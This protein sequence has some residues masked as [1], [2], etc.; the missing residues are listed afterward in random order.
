VTN[1]IKCIISV[2][3]VAISFQGFSQSCIYSFKKWQKA[4]GLLHRQVD[5]IFQDHYGFMWFGFENGIQR[6]DGHQFKSW[7][8]IDGSNKLYSI[9]RFGEDD[10][11]WLWLWNSMLDE[12]LFLNTE[13]EE[14]QTEKG[15]LKRNPYIKS[16]SKGG[17]WIYQ[18]DRIPKD[19]A[20]N[21]VFVIGS[22]NRI[23]RF[24]SKNGFQATTIKTN[25]KG[26]YVLEYL[27][28]HGIL[29]VY[30]V[31]KSNSIYAISPDGRILKTFM[32]SD[33]SEFSNF[34]QRGNRI[35]FNRKS[36]GRH[37]LECIENYELVTLKQSTDKFIWHFGKYIWK[38]ESTSF[39]VQGYEQETK[40][41]KIAIDPVEKIYRSRRTDFFEDETGKIWMA[42]PYGLLVFQA[43]EKVLMTYLKSNEL[44]DQLNNSSVRGIS[45]LGSMLYANVE[46]KGIVAINTENNQVN[47]AYTD[48]NFEG[49]PLEKIGNK[50]VTGT[51]NRILIFERVNSGLELSKSYKT[52]SKRP[53]WSILPSDSI[54]LVGTNKGLY[55]LKTQG[56]NL[57]NNRVALLGNTSQLGDIYSIKKD[58][59]NSLWLCTTTGLHKYN[60]HSEAVEFSIGQGGNISTP[61]TT[62]YAMFMGK[63]RLWLG[64]EVGL[65][66][67]DT[68]T[69]TY[70]L[71]NT[72]L[73]LSNDKIY[74]VLPDLYDNLWLSSDYGLMKFNIKTKRVTSFHTNHGLTDNE[75]NRIS[76]F[77]SD[78]DRIWFGS[79]N[80]LNSISPS[81]FRDDNR[82]EERKLL[83]SYVGFSEKDTTYD[84]TLAARND[85]QIVL[86]HNYSS[87]SIHISYPGY[88]DDNLN[89]YAWTLDPDNGSW[90]QSSTNQLQI[91]K[92][93]YGDNK[94]YIKA[95]S[96]S[97]QEVIKSVAMEVLRPFYL[98][99]QFILL[100][101]LSSL[102]LTILYTRFRTRRLRQ[103]EIILQSRIEESVKKIKQD[104]E[105]IEEQAKDLKQL[106]KVKS[107]F[108]QNIS[109]EL[110]TP[111]T[112]ILGPLQNALS[113]KDV[114]IP[115]KLR[116]LL[117]ISLNN[118]VKL[119]ERVEE[120]LNLSKLEAGTLKLDLVATHLEE[121]IKNEVT[122]YRELAKRNDI[123]IIFHNTLKNDLVVLLDAKKTIKVVD[124]LLSNAIKHSPKKTTINVTLS[125][126]NEHFLLIVTDEGK[127][128]SPDEE[129]AIF[130]RF[131][132]TKE[133]E[134]KGG[135]GIG[136]SMCRNLARLMDGDVK[137]APTREQGASFVFYFKANKT[138]ATARLT[139]TSP[140]HATSIRRPSK[141]QDKPKILVVEDNLEM[142]EY[143]KAVLID[144]EVFE[145]EN[146]V[147]ALDFLKHNRV[148][149]I[150]TDMMMP[151]M[152]G[153][154]FYKNLKRNNKA[155]TPVVVI[156]AKSEQSSIVNALQ[157]GIDDYLTKPFY[158]Q[159]LIARVE[160]LLKRQSIRQNEGENIATKTPFVDRLKKEVLKNIG[161]NAFTVL[162]L[163]ENLGISERTLNRKLKREVGLSSAAYIK[164]I[165]LN[166]AL[167]LLQA[168]KLESVK[169]V[170]NAVGFSRQDYFAK[171]FVSRFGKYPKEYFE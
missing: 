26:I 11:N 8:K 98:K 22:P 86:P 28:K 36:N 109:H 126:N 96:S 138:N 71:Y 53:I 110:R 169:E 84:C 140:I 57:A 61:A 33:K 92:L 21:L 111:L 105:L 31:D 163:C 153:L 165:R 132:Q 64:T 139:T 128:V 5:A 152:N 88:T 41:K 1:L 168:Q 82:R 51:N 4:D 156:S 70:R 62:V 76:Y 46:R 42:S 164:E 102:T 171:Q 20:G 34:H 158:A 23:I 170:S 127:G 63:K 30:N 18:K 19:S 143:I 151:K 79:L 101:I 124:N 115:T 129:E 78:P 144:Y 160:S 81:K 87:F 68:S 99:P 27:D 80:G 32:W 157:T 59:N 120:L 166:E 66:S 141:L 162:N 10:G 94:I 2:C 24:N 108:F 114:R 90:F 146:G 29:W 122:S 145:A 104:K 118:T 52:P 7:T 54:I 45:S 56:K 155:N 147:E 167:K 117:G 38:Q 130:E 113:D 142:R 148:D 131:Y 67:V 161:N 49:R 121:L 15:Y 133:G 134:E 136:L 44:E 77:K 106:D 55:L 14:I 13:S 47:L 37:Y 116:N 93:P 72:D 73:G 154:S 85:K 58:A 150:A 9:T 75:F 135:V 149:L 16:V 50:L 74:A 60:W 65:I 35:Y 112:L 125:K 25:E 89:R 95:S 159:E 12:F 107:Q 43:N 123:K 48:A 83:W 97:G 119:N 137:L 6:Y 3:I 103:N 100:L 17:S 91:G 69:S 39:S 40:I